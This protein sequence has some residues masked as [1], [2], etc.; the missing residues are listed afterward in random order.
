MRPKQPEGDFV[1]RRIGFQNAYGSFRSAGASGISF[2]Y[3]LLRSQDI[4]RKKGMI[5]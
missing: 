5:Q 2:S 1:I 3:I 4:V